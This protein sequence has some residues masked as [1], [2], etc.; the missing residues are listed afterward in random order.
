MALHALIFV[1]DYCDDVESFEM[2]VRAPN[3]VA[4]G[5]DR[6]HNFG[7]TSHLIDST[8]YEIV[9]VTNLTRQSRNQEG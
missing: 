3:V 2:L 4:I 9:D 7:I 6:D 1:D 8:L 5:F